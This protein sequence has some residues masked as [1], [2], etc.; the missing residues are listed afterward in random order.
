THVD[1]FFKRTR[2]ADDLDLL[3]VGLYRHSWQQ[4]LFASEFGRRYVL[5]SV[6]PAIERTYSVRLTE[7]PPADPVRLLLES[8]PPAARMVLDHG[9]SPSNLVKDLL[10][11][12]VALT[13]ALIDF[14]SDPERL[15]EGP[16]RTAIRALTDN[17]G[18]VAPT[19]RFLEELAL[20]GGFSQE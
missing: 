9:P 11:A 1:N 4:E 6:F 10:L 2:Q 8:C 13:G 12:Q 14:H 16:V 18:T 15:L 19:V 5:N 17:N 7:R 3:F 20:L